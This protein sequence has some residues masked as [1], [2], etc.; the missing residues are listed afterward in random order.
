MS[1]L[2]SLN[3]IIKKSVEYKISKECISEQG[4]ML[5]TAMYDFIAENKLDEK[6]GVVIMN[7]IPQFT[8]KKQDAKIFENDR[9][10]V[11]AVNE[12]EKQE[13]TI[14]KE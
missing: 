9:F 5:I 4:K 2:N 11:F 13:T 14:E 1:K 10:F 3:E 6:L 7:G 8:T 12:S